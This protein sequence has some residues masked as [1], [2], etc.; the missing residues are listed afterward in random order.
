MPNHI[1]VVC[2]DR[3]KFLLHLV[4]MAPCRL[5]YIA[6]T[7]LGLSKLSQLPGL[8]VQV[9][10]WGSWFGDHTCKVLREIWHSGK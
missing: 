4:D 2:I 3:T 1:P 9:V 6:L 10:G 8:S 7:Q 5:K